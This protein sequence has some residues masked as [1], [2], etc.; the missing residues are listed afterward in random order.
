MISQKSLN[1]GSLR[2][3]T[4]WIR[5]SQQSRGSVRQSRT[6]RATGRTADSRIHADVDW[7]APWTICLDAKQA[8]C[9]TFLPGLSL[10]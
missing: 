10:L 5:V 3:E 4:H 2:P 8:G 1:N 9:L 7:T 6:S